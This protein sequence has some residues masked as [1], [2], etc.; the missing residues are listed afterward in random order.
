MY[1]AI[2]LRLLQYVVT[3]AEE[4]SFTRAARKLF[5]AQPALSKQIKDLE[6]SLGV[7]L[8]ERTTR[9]V[10]LTPAGKV[11]V[12][13]ARAA[14]AHSERARDLAKAVSRH[15]SSPLS[16]GFS[17]H[18]NV[19]L[20]TILKKRATSA[21]G[22]DGA[23]FTSSFTPEQVQHVLD[24]R[25]DVGIGIAV[26]PHPSL[27]THLLMQEP[28]GV[29][30]AKDHKLC[31]RGT[32]TVRL[33]EI[34]NEPLIL[35]PEKL[36]PDLYREVRQFWGNL[37]YKF[38][39]TQ[40]VTTITEAIGLVS[41]GMGISFAKLSTRHIMPPSV[42]MMELPK[43]ECPTITMS[44]FVRKNGRSPKADKFLSILANLRRPH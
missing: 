29:I 21:F 7:K 1:P 22:K 8:F 39:V 18:L 15:D 40:E 41:A 6:T 24:G 23:V 32:N 33:E 43:V 12:E 28:A 5:I 9:Q 20:L 25:L 34:K 36:N 4:L 2:E 26:A 44:A 27:E 19:E 17:P 42:K 35:L 38:R 11:F 13:E 3:I 10:V 37:G 16:V 31:K 30:I 14:L